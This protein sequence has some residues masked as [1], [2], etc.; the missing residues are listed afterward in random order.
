MN[1][2]SEIE[3]YTCDLICTSDFPLE[4]SCDSNV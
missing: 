2:A 1:F 4:N 3:I